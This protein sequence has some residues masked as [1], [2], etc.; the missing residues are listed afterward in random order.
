MSESAKS[1]SLP[2]LALLAGGLATRL[3]PVT[4]TIPKSMLRVGGEPFVAHQLRLLRDQGIRQVVLCVG[5]LGEQ[6]RDFVGDGSAYG[7]AVQYSFDGPVLKGT[8]GA[9]KQALPLLGD[10]FLIMYGD[11]YLPTSFALV[12]ER[13]A[14]SGAEGLM[15]VFHNGNRWDKSNV[16]FGEGRIVRYDKSH[17]DASMEYIDYGLGI[18]RAE[19]FDSWESEDTFDLAR[20]Y[21]SLVARGQL[22]GYEVKERFF[23]IGSHEGLAEADTSLFHQVK[24]LYSPTGSHPEL[25]D[26]PGGHS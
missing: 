18:L 7:L 21:E 17:P 19:A 8:G 22:A 14:E 9:I 10:H 26:E 2:S 13:F 6:L 5:H 24:N 16:E 15:T 1:R 11:S 20:V 25:T 23:E 12:Y 4:A 3:R